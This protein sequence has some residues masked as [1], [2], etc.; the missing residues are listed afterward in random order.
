MHSSA[1]EGEPINSFALVGYIPDPLGSFLDGL[2]IELVPGC[3]AQSHVTLLPPRPLASAHDAFVQLHQNLCNATPLELELGD[4]EIFPVTNVVYIAIRRG[5]QE[6]KELHARLNE[7]CVAFQEPFNYHPHVTLAQEIPVCDLPAITDLARRRWRE[8][9]HPR[10]IV[11]DN[12]TF[13]QNTICPSNGAS[14]WIDLG[15]IDL[16]R[17]VRVA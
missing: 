10:Q 7:G 15:H 14:R 6:L 13:V 4:I 12:L 8:C 3:T 16:S 11:L 2:R 5:F 17:A 9:G 1:S